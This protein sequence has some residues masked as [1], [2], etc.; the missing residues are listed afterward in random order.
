MFNARIL[1]EDFERMWKIHEKEFQ[2]YLRYII[3]YG[4]I[5]F[6]DGRMYGV[7]EHL[8][9]CLGAYTLRYYYKLEVAYN[10]YYLKHTT[11]VSH[12]LIFVMVRRDPILDTIEKRVKENP[13]EAQLWAQR[14]EN[15]LE[16]STIKDVVKETMTSISWCCTT[17]GPN[18][19]VAKAH[20]AK[21]PMALQVAIFRVDHLVRQF[22]R[23]LRRV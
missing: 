13:M 1:I 18:L 8:T 4:Y 12:K 10:K 23:D 5:V 20:L 22:R 15:L 21:T 19:H 6:N 7:L 16:S 17:K 14:L 9:S 2:E 3:I 11:I